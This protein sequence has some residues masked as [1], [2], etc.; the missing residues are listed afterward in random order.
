MPRASVAASMKVTAAICLL[1]LALAGTGTAK[2]R[3]HYIAAEEVMWNYAP[4]G[5]NVFKGVPLL[6]DP[7]SFP[8]FVEGPTFIGGTYIKALFFE[9][10]D[11]T[12]TEKKDMG[13]DWE[14]MGFLGPPLFAEVGDTFEV[15]SLSL[16]P[17]LPSPP[18]PLA[19]QLLSI[20]ERDSV[21]R[22]P[23]VCL[24]YSP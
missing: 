17:P 21:V 4:T 10:T 18:C 23:V 24:V 22:L 20:F 12:F 19:P 5:M 13:P 15:G 6:E 2:V 16:P 11:A 9:Y 7:E 1:L 14:H 3:T 8:F